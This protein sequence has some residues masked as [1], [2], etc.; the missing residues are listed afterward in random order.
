[1]SGAGSPDLALDRVL[2]VINSSVHT[3]RF[4][5][6]NSPVCSHEMYCRIRTLQ[7]ALVGKGKVALLFVDFYGFFESSKL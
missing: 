1:M 3:W 4:A 2:G 5:W 7:F 6:T